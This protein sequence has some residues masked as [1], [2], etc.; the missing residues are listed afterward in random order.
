MPS[1]IYQRKPFTE[2]H[3]NKIR[4]SNIG[5]KRSLECRKILSDAHKGHQH[6]EE[7]KR[8][9]SLSRKG[10][11]R[12]EEQRK[13][14]SEGLKGKKF[15]DERKKQI[16][17]L[18]KG[19]KMSEETKLKMSLAHKGKKYKPMSEQGK[20]NLRKSA[21]K[22][23]KSPKWK[24][25]ITPINKKIRTTIEYNLWRNSIFARDGFICQH[26][27]I[28]G[29]YLQ[30]HHIKPFALFPELR[31]A[32]DNGITLCKECHKKHHKLFGKLKIKMSRIIDA[33]KI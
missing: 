9:M 13:R 14:I 27:K 3:I 22:G 11:K 8:K 15:S 29:L 28:K 25:G 24:G 20:M 4:I 7:T 16:G 12:T 31:F 26:C 19:T 18:K 5:K 6:S 21:L 1:G 30:A 10:Q 17:L 32:I 33:Y 2:D 23:E